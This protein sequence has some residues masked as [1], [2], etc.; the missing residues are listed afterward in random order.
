MSSAPRALHEDAAHGV[1]HLADGQAVRQE[2]AGVAVT[3]QLHAQ[4][5]ILAQRPRRVP[6][7]LRARTHQQ[8]ESGCQEAACQ[9]R[10]PGGSD[11][12]EIPRR[13]PCVA[14]AG[15]VTGASSAQ[16]GCARPPASM[17]TR[18]SAGR[19][20]PPGSGHASRQGLSHWDIRSACVHWAHSAELRHPRGPLRRHAC[21]RPQRGNHAAA[22]RRIERPADH[23]MRAGRALSSA[24]ERTA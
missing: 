4:A 10:L 3:L 24:R 17:H 8:A 12:K 13:Q 21:S 18:A 7:R 15:N 23:S 6:A 19:G 2:V 5:H 22:R 9:T 16:G 20:G 11:P 14:R 1:G